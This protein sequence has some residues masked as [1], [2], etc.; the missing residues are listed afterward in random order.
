MPFA[1]VII[2]GK[3][4]NKAFADDYYRMERAFKD[5]FGLDIIVSDGVRTYEEQ[6]RGY[7]DYISGRTSVRWANPDSPQAYHVETNKSGPRAIDIRDSGNTAGVTRY[8]N[9]RSN[10]IR[11]N[12]RKYNWN[13]R[14]Y[15]EFNEP[16]H[17]EHT[18]TPILE[19]S[20]KPGDRLNEDGQLGPQTISKLQSVLGVTVDG[21]MGPQTISALQ[22]RVGAGV[23]GKLGPETIS[24]MQGRLGVKVD[25]QWGAQTTTALQKH[26][27]NGGNLSAPAPKPTPVPV[28]TD[29]LLVDGQL[30]KKTIEKWQKS[31]GATVDG[32]LGP[33]TI[34]KTQKLVGARV[35]GQLGPQ[36]I[37]AIQI[38]V[39][40]TPDGQMGPQTIKK[41]QEFLNAG[42]PFTAVAVEPEAPATQD[43]ADEDEATPDLKTPSANDFPSWIRFEKILDPEGLKPTLNIDAKK[44]YSRLYNPIESHIHWWGAPGK[45]GSHDGNVNHIKNTDNLSVNFVVSAGRITL[46]VPL[47]KI[48]L[49]TGARNPYAWK[50]EN[51]PM[52]T[53]LS[54][55]ELG[56]RT[57]G[58]LHY[59]VEK[60][61]PKLLNEPIRH[62][63]EFYPTSC[64]ELDKA[65]VRK[66]AEDFRTG[67]LDPNTGKPPV[68]TSPVVT[69][70]PTPTPT[71]QPQPETVSIPKGLFTIVKGL[72]QELRRLADDIDEYLV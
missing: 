29:V 11:D 46:M 41:L 70:T 37:K 40:A 60:L 15:H 25:G 19:S 69:P 22:R 58:Y 24:K 51:D 8:G 62:H 59:I 2:D 17:L 10:W 64:S 55:D 42:K 52:I 68:T 31:V 47:N 50:S 1:Y 7:N 43:P 57:M 48:A 21:Q 33:E 6:K 9:A 13:P 38:N 45:G 4:V 54:N 26:L 16:W 28:P 14:G 67:R 44:Y 3:R 71:P 18:G 27:N 20:W 72:P 61:N 32:E 23:D 39:G 35:D 49:T 53:D 30:G 66:Y 34:S 12:A 56:Y 36:T 63:K 65:K 5:A